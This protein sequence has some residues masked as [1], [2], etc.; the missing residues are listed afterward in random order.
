MTQLLHQVYTPVV[1]SYLFYWFIVFWEDRRERERGRVRERDGFHV[2]LQIPQQPW[3]SK[4]GVEY[5]V[6]ISHVVA[7]TQFLEPSLP[8]P[9]FCVSRK[10]ESGARARSWTQ[11]LWCGMCHSN[12]CQKCQAKCLPLTPTNSILLHVNS[13]FSQRHLLERRPFP[14]EWSWHPCGHPYLTTYS[15]VCFWDSFSTLFVYM[16]V[17]VP[18]PHCSL[19]QLCS[20]YWNQEARVLQVCSFSVL[21]SHSRSL[22]FHRNFWVN[23]SLSTKNDIEILLEI[24]LNL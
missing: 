22:T 7:E 18:A 8:P 15:S 16:S 11:A 13:R 4:P 12:W 10:L 21:S 23:F 5:S 24:T 1:L 20:I 6:Q 14:L 19:L 17:C 2:L 3:G 9:R